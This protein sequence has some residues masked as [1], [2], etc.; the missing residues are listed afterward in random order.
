MQLLGKL[1]QDVS[2][3]CRALSAKPT[4]VATQGSWGALDGDTPRPPKE[5][6][7]RA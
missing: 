7:L 4:G 6:L 2:L 5:E 1:T 3:V